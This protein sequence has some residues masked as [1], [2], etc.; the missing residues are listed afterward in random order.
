MTGLTARL[1]PRTV[2]ALVL[3]STG[4][5]AKARPVPCAVPLGNWRMLPAQHGASAFG[6]FVSQARLEELK[7]L[8]VERCVAGFELHRGVQ[9]MQRQVSDL[10]SMRANLVRSKASAQNVA[11]VDGSIAEAEREADDMDRERVRANAEAETLRVEMWLHVRLA[12][13]DP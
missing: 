4:S 5:E 12:G 7:A 1:S 9:R 13:V 6:G 10:R 8:Y 2:G 3:S 11:A